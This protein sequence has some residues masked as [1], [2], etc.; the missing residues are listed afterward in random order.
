M[1]SQSTPLVQRRHWLQLAVAAATTPW[2]ARSAW[3]QPKLA[4]NP[5]TL[6][7][8]SGSPTAD[9]M[10]LWTRLMQTGL[11][12][13]SNLGK[14][15][16]TLRWELA[17]D[18]GFKQIVQSGQ[19]SALPELGHS[20]HVEVS[21]LVP[22]ERWYFYRFMLG[23]VAS[24]S[25]ATGNDWVSPTGRTRTLPAANSALAKL[26]LAYASCQRWE[27]G[28][29]S[30]YTHMLADQPDAVVFLGDYIYEYPTAANAVRK[31]TGGWVTTLDEYRARYAMHKSDPELQSMHA[32]CPWLVTWDDH[33]VQNDYAGLSPGDAGPVVVDFAARRAAA[34]QAF[35]ENMPL[36]ASV[37]QAGTAGLAAGAEMRIYN[38]LRFG[39]LATLHLL[40]ARQYKNTLV[41]TKGGAAGAGSV[42]PAQCPEW[43]D[44]N[45][46]LLGNAQER[47][48][49]ES[50][51]RNKA[52]KGWQI[53]GQST[54]FG[55]RDFRVGPGQL[56]SNDGWDG[57]TPARKRL[58]DTL[59]AQKAPNV[60]VLGGDIH[61]N[62]V[63]H[64]LADYAKPNSKALGVEFCG[65]SITSNASNDKTD[66]RLAENP[67][68]VFADAQ[69]RGYGLADFTPGQLNVSLRVVDDVRNPKTQVQTLAKFA[70]QA[71]QSVIEKA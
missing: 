63:G 7:V 6:G 47:W 68:F 4:S 2:L 48:L 39:S 15:A 19:A 52:E 38:S 27:H 32:H 56:F 37:L 18:E 45:R 46:S 61:A 65:T 53:I 8:A 20:V 67:H 54:V 31:P 35:Y 42:N 25:G 3:A 24:N 58:T 33:E 71:G 28:Y 23:G 11:L 22:S 43:L 12:G 51:N 44:P 41:C 34:Y 49:G 36:R 70:V 69:Y 60:V 1:S 13:S 17:Q 62:W 29:Y 66:E 14:E 59:Q 16:I 50:L 57:Y 30:A 64:I 9:G 55:P 40:D 26:R 21:G 10:V 5:F